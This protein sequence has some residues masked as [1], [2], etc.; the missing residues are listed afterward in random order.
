MLTNKGTKSAAQYCLFDQL[1]LIR[2]KGSEA[3]MGR[4]SETEV[5]FFSESTEH[6]WHFDQETARN[7]RNSA[8]ESVFSSD[9][10]SNRNRTTRPLELCPIDTCWGYGGW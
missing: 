1:P 10:R 8:A 6:T 3:V 4:H 2:P 9:F 5:P 7:P